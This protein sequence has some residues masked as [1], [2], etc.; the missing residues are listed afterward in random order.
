MREAVIVSVARTPIGRAKKG[1]LRDTRPEVFAAEV[2][3]ALLKRTPGL[4]PAMVDDVVVGCAM[5][6]GEQGMNIARV[7]TL[8]AGFPVEVPAMTVNRFCS[9]GSQTIALAADTIKA[10][11]NEIVI[12][13]GVESMSM[14]PMGGNKLIAEPVLMD[15]MPNAYAGMGTTAEVVARKY[16]ITRQMQDE[17]A[18]ASHRKAAAAIE[19]G[20]FKQE[21]V[22]LQVRTRDNG[23]WTD[24]TF[25]TDE[26]PRADTTLEALAKLK[27]VF[28]PKGTVTAGNASQ[29]NDGSAMVVV[30]SLE[31]ARA[32]GLAPIA[33][34]RDW[35][36]AGV[37]P[38]VMGIGPAAAVPKLLKKAG[39]T[40]NDVDLVEINEAFASQTVY[41]R[42]K[43]G[44]PIDRLNVDGGAIAIGHP[45]GMSGAR[46]VGHALIEGRRRNVRYVV[47]TMCVGGGMGA[48]G[49]FEVA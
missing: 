49:L 29:I 12:A 23:K 38:D 40:L 18:V 24:F 17:Y 31:R 27:P 32:M 1:S 47:V 37:E 3:K 26:G 7:I 35:A 4:D 42:D 16:N 11:S 36:V 39:L 8:L 28:D 10:G 43:L 19:A 44:I 34:V 20:R 14:V 45:F 5:P 15:A 21:I 6:E 33:F 41:C 2:L 9:S 48:A 25:S 22:P 13:G 46:M 30:M